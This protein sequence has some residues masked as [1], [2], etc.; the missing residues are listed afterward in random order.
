M[1][2]IGSFAMRHHGIEVDRLSLDI[3]FISTLEEYNVYKAQLPAATLIIDTPSKKV[4]DTGVIKLE[5]DIAKEGD[6]NWDLLGELDEGGLTYAPIFI[7]LLLKESHKYKKDSPHFLKTM[8]DIKTLRKSE[9]SSIPE[10]PNFNWYSW[11]DKREKETYTN[12]LPK[13]NQ[14]KDNFFD[15][16]GVVYTYDHDSIHKAIKIHEKPAYE[17]FKPEDKDVWCSRELWEDCSNLIKLSAVLEESGVLALERSLIPHGF[18]DRDHQREVFKY[19]LQKVCTSI[20][21]GWFREFS[22]EHYEEVMELYDEFYYDFVERFSRGLKEG[23][24]IK[25]ESKD[26]SSS[27]D[28]Q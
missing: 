18:G 17:H 12:H 3:D 15:T 21:S 4:L 2:V 6:S 20:T 10:S 8:K 26:E 7:L 14:S 19:A 24:V 25:L 28:N 1:L 5:F 9:L 23:V 27:S 11:Y 16:D 22:Y 13:L